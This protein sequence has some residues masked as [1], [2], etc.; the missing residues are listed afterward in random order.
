MPP[1][2]TTSA[3]FVLL[4]VFFALWLVFL[5]IMGIWMLRLIPNTGGFPIE[6]PEEDDDK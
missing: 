3:C 5:V 1:D 6:E 4:Q 2:H